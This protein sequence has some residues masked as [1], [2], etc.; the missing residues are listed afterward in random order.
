MNEVD[1]RLASDP[2]WELFTHPT[3]RSAQE[4][5]GTRRYGRWLV[6]AGLVALGWLLF[7]PLAVVGLPPVIWSTANGS[8]IKGHKHLV[9]IIL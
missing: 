1:D 2:V 4:A 9:I 6:V 7:P 5:L 8:S 3:P